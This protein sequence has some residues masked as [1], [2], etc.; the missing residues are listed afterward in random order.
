VAERTH[1]GEG[2]VAVE[3]LKGGCMSVVVGFILLVLALFLIAYF[4]E[5]G[6]PFQVPTSVP[7]PH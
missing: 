6:F 4:T 1:Q 3:G 2:A 7:I 5:N